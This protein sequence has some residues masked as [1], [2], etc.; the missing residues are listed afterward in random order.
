MDNDA[1]IKVTHPSRASFVIDK[2]EIT[3]ITEITKI[4]QIQKW[5]RGCMCRLKRL[6]LIMDKFRKHLES[7]AFQF[8][9]QNED[10]RI[11]S[12][13]DEEKVI[14]LLVEEFG[15]K[16]KKPKIRMWYDILA[17]D[18][19]YGWIPINIKTTTTTTS[20]NTGNLAMCVYA[21]TDE[22]LD[23]HRNKSYEN[24]KM[25]DVLFDKLKNKKY[26]TSS[27]KDYYF[28]VLNKTNASDVIVNSVKGLTTL[29]P[30]I[31]N[32]PFQV[33]WNKNRIFK[34]ENM[35]EKIKQFIDCLQKPNPSWKEVFMT[36]IRTLD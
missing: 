20:D 28:I 36:N 31:N 4:I 6:P 15:E 21:Y 29:T 16:I 1:Q 24:G 3:E 25:S 22:M 10:G 7:Q 33:C 12:C 8:S 18:Y 30:N 27:K 17:F 34:Y 23:I 19:M 35:T 26:N 32:L 14:K 5:F 11:N 2:T 13:M 9:T